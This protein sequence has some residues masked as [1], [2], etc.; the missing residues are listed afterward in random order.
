V[1]VT[2]LE[3]ERLLLRPIVPADVDRLV[4]LDSDPDVLRFTDPLGEFPREPG[5]M[6]RHLLE[7]VIPRMEATGDGREDRGFWALEERESGRFLGWLHLKPNDRPEAPE[8]GYRLVPAA[9]GHG[10]VTEASRAL[11]ELA[12]AD[13]DVALVWAHTMRENDASRRVMGRLGMTHRE[14]SDYRGVPTVVY[15]LRRDDP[16]A[17]AG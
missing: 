5:E 2:T 12:F 8:L 1:S 15:A 10:Y 14:D 6:R 16:G 7:T 17:A 9:R 11:L 3:T 13:P 4:E